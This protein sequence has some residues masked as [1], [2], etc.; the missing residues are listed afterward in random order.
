MRTGPLKDVIT[1]EQEI[2]TGVGNLNAPIKSWVAWREDVLC[3]VEAKRGREHWDSATNQ[4]IS[5]VVTLFRCHL[6]DVVG[7]DTTM[8]IKFEGQYYDIRDPRP[9]HVRRE[10]CI[11]EGKLQDHTVGLGDLEVFGDPAISGTVGV[12]YAS[13]FTARGGAKPYTFS[14]A[15]GALP[16]G[17]TISSYDE[18][19]WRISGTPTASGAFP[20]IVVRVTDADL[21]TIDLDAFDL[22]IAPGA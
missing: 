9:D 2:Q 22:T 4:R 12:A 11:I 3:E 1:I 13:F 15:S 17:L 7:L 14:I 21:D 6:D 20:D 18:K 16:S 10:D 8:R 19:T 5:E